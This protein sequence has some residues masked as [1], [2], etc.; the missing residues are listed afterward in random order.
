MIFLTHLSF[1]LLL[2]LTALMSY[3]PSISAVLFLAVAL[4][5]SLLPDI[6]C[7]TSTLGK[8]IRPLSYFLEHRGFFHSIVFVIIASLVVYAVSGAVDYSLAFIL[9]YGSHLLLDCLNPSGVMLLW[10]LRVKTKEPFRTGKLVDL[11]LLILFLMLSGLLLY[12]KL[13]R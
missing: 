7:A 13:F 9:G 6:D 4:V 3:D 5:S 11:G 12:F 1:A 10:P 2:A 8:R